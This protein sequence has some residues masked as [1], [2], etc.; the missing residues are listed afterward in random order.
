MQ[1]GYVPKN[2]SWRRN[3]QLLPA[4]RRHRRRSV[5]NNGVQ[6]AK[7]RTIPPQR[8]VESEWR[9]IRDSPSNASFATE[10]SFEGGTA[11]NDPRRRRSPPVRTQQHSPHMPIR[12]ACKAQCNLEAH[13][14][15][16]G[17]LHNATSERPT[18]SVPLRL[19]AAFAA[20][21]RSPIGFRHNRGKER[22][23]HT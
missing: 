22:L 14:E 13:D 9:W 4:N 20:D 19:P 16:S 10:T 3:G 2:L 23:L 21:F 1:N 18:I 7:V 17:R 15:S 12:N 8:P 6:L 5:R 11:W